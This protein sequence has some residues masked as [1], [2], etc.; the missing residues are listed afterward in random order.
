MSGE[1]VQRD[2]DLQLYIKSK[3]DK[4]YYAFTTLCFATLALSIQFSPQMGKAW[5]YLL[6]VSWIAYLCASIA[7]GWW[8]MISPQFDQFS[9]LENKL[10]NSIAQRKFN[11]ENPIYLQSLEAGRVINS[12]TNKPMTKDD[13]LEALKTEETTL[14]DVKKKD[15]EPINKKM[16]CLFKTQIWSYIIALV[17]NGVFIAKNFLAHETGI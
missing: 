9:R 2:F 14:A 7:G 13:V 12:D 17:L 4:F 5:P 11:V 16:R 8:L 15:L 6:I 3:A 10:E 1:H